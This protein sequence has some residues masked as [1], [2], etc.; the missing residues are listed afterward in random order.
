LG[1]SALQ[2]SFITP[3]HVGLQDV[4]QLPNAVEDRQLIG[5]RALLLL[6]FALGSTAGRLLAPA[7]G[8]RS[9]QT[10]NER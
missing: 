8:R 5:H 6:S 4:E 2:A 10:A 9:K 3:T 1:I 7:F